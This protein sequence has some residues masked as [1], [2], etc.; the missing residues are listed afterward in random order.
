MEFIYFYFVLNLF[1]FFIVSVFRFFFR[2]GVKINIKASQKKKE[3]EKKNLKSIYTTRKIT[4]S[5]KVWSF[6]SKY[7]LTNLIAI[8]Q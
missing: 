3:R 4:Q 8:K 1:S 7:Y 6:L 2:I 5:N